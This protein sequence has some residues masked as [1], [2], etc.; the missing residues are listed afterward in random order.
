MPW[1]MGAPLLNTLETLHIAS[2]INKIDARLPVQTVL[3]PQSGEHRDY[4]GYAGRLATIIFAVAP[5]LCCS[6]GLDH[7][8][9]EQRRILWRGVCFDDVGGII[10]HIN[11][12]RSGSFF[13]QVSATIWVLSPRREFGSADSSRLPPWSTCRRTVVGP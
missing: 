12:S 3:R 9:V 6:W 1:Y 13:G 11:F 2:D 10:L 5:Q 7:M 4:R 8:V